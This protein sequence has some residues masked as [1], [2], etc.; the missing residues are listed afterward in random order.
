MANKCWKKLKDVKLDNKTITRFDGNGKRIYISNNGFSVETIP[1]N[2]ILVDKR[3]K[4]K[5]QALRLAR[6]Y[7]KKNNTC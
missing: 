4:T 5:S 1:N 2:N 3:T 6:S 7:M